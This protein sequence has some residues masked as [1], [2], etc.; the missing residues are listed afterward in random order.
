MRMG[1][2]ISCS[3][4]AVI[5]RLAFTCSLKKAFS[6]VQRGEKKKL[7]MRHTVQCSF[8]RAIFLLFPRYS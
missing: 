6:D 8:T 1:N 5:V 2:D 7:S 3:V 4:H